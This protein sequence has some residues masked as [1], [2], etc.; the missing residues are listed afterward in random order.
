MRSKKIS[1]V[2]PV[3]NNSESIQLVATE[4]LNIFKLINL[5]IDYELILVNDGSSDSSWK[6]IQKIYAENPKNVVAIDLLQNYGQLN[7]LLAGYEEAKGD[8]V[9]SMSADL[10]DPPSLIPELINSW[11][12]GNTLVIARRE[13]RDDGL[14]KDL[15]SNIAWG[16]LKKYAIQNLPKGGFDYFLM[17]AAIKNK[18]INEPEQIIF[19]QGRLLSYVEE[20][21]AVPY[22][23]VRRIHGKSQ[24]DFNKKM[25]FFLDGVIGYSNTPL[26]MISVIC[27]I[28]FILSIAGTVFLIIFTLL[29]GTKV[30]GWASQLVIMLLFNGMQLFAIAVIGEYVRRI[31]YELRKRPRYIISQIIKG[32]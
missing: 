22:N 23:R 17:D 32:S 31:L 5:D 10:Q 20:A 4:V 27:L 29:N 28:F 19:M 25:K 2:V 8:A 26:L 30:D 18:Y 7:A 11:V 21:Y 9:I 14:V 3:F 15:V 24:T 12:C 16:F 13:N 1:I 6:I